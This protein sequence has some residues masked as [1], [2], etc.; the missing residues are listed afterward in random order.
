MFILAAPGQLVCSGGGGGSGGGP[1]T[2]FPGSPPI[3]GGPDSPG[4]PCGVAG[5]ALRTGKVWS[6]TETFS[7]SHQE[8][9]DYPDHQED[10]E[11]PGKQKR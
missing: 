1:L 4:S 10:L 6:L 9:Q 8:L 3:P 2:F 11:G 7:P 5:L